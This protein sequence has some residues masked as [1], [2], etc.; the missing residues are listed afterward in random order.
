MIELRTAGLLYCLSV[1]VIVVGLWLY[2]DRRERTK[3][4]AEARKATFHC[5]KCDNLYSSNQLSSSVD[6]P[7]CG[8]S[9]ARLRF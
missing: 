6:C 3:Y 9:N 4:E 5:I 1:G 8:H 2:Y 7:K